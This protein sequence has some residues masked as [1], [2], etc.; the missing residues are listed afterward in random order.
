MHKNI[1]SLFQNC[2]AGQ[3]PDGTQTACD[4][5]SAGSYS[6][7]GIS[8]TTCPKGIQLKIIKIVTNRYNIF[9]TSLDKSLLLLLF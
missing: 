4:D 3:E 9:M 2:N 8:C 5:C 6:T 1:C 7:D